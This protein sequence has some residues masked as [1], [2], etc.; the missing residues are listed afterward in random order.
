M[1]TASPRIQEL[2]TLIARTQ[3]GY[4]LDVTKLLCLAHEPDI[5]L[6][7]EAL[8]EGLPLAC[9]FANFYVIFTRA[10]A[11]AVAQMNEWKGRPRNQTGSISTTSLRI[12]TLFDWSRLPPTLTEKRVLDVMEAFLE[13][14]PIGFRG[15]AAEDLPSHMTADDEGILTS[16]AIVPGYRCPSNKLISRAI[17]KLPERYLYITSANISSRKT[18]VE[19]PAHWKP[20]PLL[21]DFRHIVDMQLIRHASE[22]AAHAEYPGYGEMSTTVLSF[23][24]PAMEGGRPALRLERHGSLHADRVRTLL[25]RFGL[26]LEVGRGGQ[27]RLL[28]RTYAFSARGP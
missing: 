25:E 27:Q 15:P 2:S 14:G 4:E 3:S 11:D 21:F 6:A 9:G 16:Q 20:A 23:H 7:V 26:G 18:G 13:A 22:D 1:D 24:R 19:E 17:E 8:L 12:P 10:D 5:D 28:E